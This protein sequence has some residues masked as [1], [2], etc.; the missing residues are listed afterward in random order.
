MMNKI[1]WWRTD[2]G[3]EEIRKVSESIANEHL[4]QGPV[5]E[6]FEKGIANTLDV[7]YVA[8]TTSGSMSILMALIAIG[9][10]PGDEVIVPNRT[11]IATAHAP[12]I[13]GAKVVLVDV[14][15]KQPI[16]DVKQIESKITPRTKAIIAVHL[17][18]RAA[19]MK[20][21]NR[22][23]KSHRL[24]V[25]EDA[26]QAFCSKN[27]DGML[28]L[29]SSMGCFSLSVAK[30][31][32]TGQGGFVVTKDEALY[33][34]LKA[35]RTHG[36]SDLINVSYTQMGFNFRFTDIQA[37]I[38]VIQLKYLNER[39]EKVKAVYR[40]YESRINEFSFL[41]LIPVNVEA[42]E[43]PIYIEVL[44]PERSKLMQFLAERN[45][46]TRPFYPCLNM[47]S[48]FENKDIFPNSAVFGTQGLFL[49]CG[50]G[51]SLENVDRVFEAL[52]AFKKHARA[53]YA[54]K[55]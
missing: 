51:Q 33:E 43:I 20:E 11:W 47:A 35:M 21:I 45:I 18:G 50:P 32:S 52:N 19:Y 49:P 3:E 7:P 38:G 28:G 13:L 10:K 14:E 2:F 9:I 27:E 26:A 15:P 6:E 16:V 34:R 44:C 24:I 36:V 54:K 55:S 29:Q 25:I 8:A 48:Y 46:Q 4:S 1:S 41:K 5:T 23:A 31:I 22:I 30:L 12:L 39:I 53:E 42:G 40:K 17:N 37:S